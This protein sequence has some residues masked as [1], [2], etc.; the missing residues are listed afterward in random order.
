MKRIEIKLKSV[1][2]VQ[3]RVGKKLKFKEQL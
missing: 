1:R 3:E 2:Y